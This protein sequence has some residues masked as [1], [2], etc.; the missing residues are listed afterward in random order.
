[1]QIK[2]IKTFAVASALVLSMAGVASATD[3]FET[4]PNLTAYNTNYT[5]TVTKSGSGRE[6]VEL[7]VQG[8]TS[9]W[10]TTSLFDSATSVSNIKWSMVDGSNSAVSI[11]NANSIA[12]SIV[13]EGYAAKKTATVDKTGNAGIAVVEAKNTKSGYTNSYMDFTVVVNPDNDN[14]IQTVSGVNVRAYDKTSGSF[15]FLKSAS[16]VVNT[17]N[18]SSS[19]NYPSAMDAI[20][21]VA[22]EDGFTYGTQY[23]TEFLKNV[24]IKD[25]DYAYKENT[26]GWMYAVYDTSDKLV[27]ISD[28]VGAESFDVK[29]GYTV[30]WAYVNGYYA[31][32]PEKL[33]DLPVTNASK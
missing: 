21:L 26:S 32:F 18:I 33:S 14:K 28:K 22:D 6:D 10:Y 8:A 11:D 2:K 23:G 5:T 4:Y 24:T 1:M 12:E 9:N 27:E 7:R 31:G 3:F 30:V 15:K 13:G 19:I 25:K 29:D 17:D 16:G 20:A